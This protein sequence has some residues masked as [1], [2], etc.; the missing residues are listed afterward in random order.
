MRARPSRTRGER[1]GARPA[2]GGRGVGLMT[3]IVVVLSGCQLS[4]FCEP[5]D[6]SE[7]TLLVEPGSDDSNPFTFPTIQAA[8]DAADGRPTT[9]CVPRGVYREELRVPSGV[10]LLGEGT[11]VVRLRPPDA[12]WVPHPGFV[13]K[14][15][16]TLEP[17]ET[18]VLTVEGIDVG[19]AAVCA[20]ATGAGN[21]YLTDVRLAGCAVGLRGDHG[22]VTVQGG[23]IRDHSSWGVHVDGVRSL[24]IHGLEITGNGESTRPTEDRPVFVGT[25]TRASTLEEISSGGALRAVGVGT[26]MV[27]DVEVT[28][29]WFG[30]ALIDLVDTG[31]AIGTSTLDGTAVVTPDGPRLAGQG[32]L[33]RA[34]GSIGYMARVRARSDGQPLVRGVDQPTTLAIESSA[35]DGRG[36]TDLASTPGPAVDLDAGGALR[37]T[38]VT[39][40]GDGAS[41]AYG[42][43]ADTEV[44]IA[45]SIAWGHTEGLD[46]RDGA[47]VTGDGV[48]DSL[49]EDV[50]VEGQDLHTPDDPDLRD[51]LSPRADS[52]ARCVGSTDVVSP[53]DLDGNPRPF[54]EGKAPDLGAIER[55]EPCP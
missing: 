16:L 15:L 51:D 19:G 52:P 26:L 2:R 7:L 8:L 50:D 6:D 43:G 35:W 25:W 47:A 24:I 53:F 10:H 22:A 13:D 29:N 46:V 27:D 11:R 37:A 4:D 21:S 41:P 31:W 1:G 32:S 18:E 44:G 23:A 12:N 48:H 36:D 28:G 9:V 40:V 3:A 17:A 5:D 54:E 14:I 38:H 45:N 20:D 34:A 30:G 49:F 55:Q 33:V 39:L 42:F